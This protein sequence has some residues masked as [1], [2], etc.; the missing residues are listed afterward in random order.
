[1]PLIV[2]IVDPMFCATVPAERLGIV[3]QPPVAIDLP[4]G[5]V[6]LALIEHAMC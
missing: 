3:E 5:L 4:L 1:M 6:L 2:V